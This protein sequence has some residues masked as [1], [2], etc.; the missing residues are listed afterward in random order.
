[1][2]KILM[3]TG[4]IVIVLGLLGFLVLLVK[5]RTTGKTS[6]VLQALKAAGIRTTEAEQRLCRQRVWVSNDML[7]TPREQHFYRAL[8]KHTDRK[9]WLLCPQVRVADIASLAPHIRPRSRT[10]W[11]LFRMASQW[12][13]DVVVVDITTFAIVA[14]VELDDASHL[15]KHRVRRDILLEEVLRQAGIPLLR[16]RDSEKLVRCVR[17]FLK[18]R[19]DITE[20]HQE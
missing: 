10:W 17:D 15:K 4:A 20:R 14:A 18:H 1:M 3:M 19:H 12:H 11:Q 16:E 2:A 8:L 7:M 5:G 6:P 13:C 9:R